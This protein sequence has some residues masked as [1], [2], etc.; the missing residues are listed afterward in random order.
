MGYVLD[1]IVGDAPKEGASNDEKNVYRTNKVDDL[2]FVQSG[3]LFAMEPDLQKLFEKMSAFEI[4]LISK[5]FLHLR[6]CGE[7]QGF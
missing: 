1:V 5:P 3:M 2:A 7:V 4:S 6:Q